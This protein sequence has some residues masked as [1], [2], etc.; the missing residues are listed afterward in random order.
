MAETALAFLLAGI[1]TVPAVLFVPRARQSPIFDRILWVG[2]WLL[3]SV[4]AFALPRNLGPDSPLNAPLIL[5]A[6]VLANFLGAL[7]GAFALNLVLW[8]MDRMNP[9]E[10]AD[11]DPEPP[12]QTD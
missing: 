12:A 6:P 1:A 3:A 10:P 5:Q 4:G 11:D 2:T 9:V 8:L 7:L